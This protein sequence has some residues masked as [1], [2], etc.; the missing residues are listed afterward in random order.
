MPLRRMLSTQ[1]TE[2]IPSLPLIDRLKTPYYIGR[3]HGW[4]DK[5]RK[6]G[7]ADCVEVTSPTYCVVLPYYLGAITMVSMPI[8]Y[9]L[10]SS[11]GWLC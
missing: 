1:A 8:I 9:K 11:S 3:V 6:N 10:Y 4:G 2:Q 7:V 5:R